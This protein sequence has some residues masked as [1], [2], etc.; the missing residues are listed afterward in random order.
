MSRPPQPPI[1]LRPQSCR[2]GPSRS[3]SG[4]STSWTNRRRT[5]PIG[6]SRSPASRSCTRC[7]CTCSKDS[8]WCPTPSAY[9]SS[10]S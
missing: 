1:H 4:T 3:R 7:G 2:V 9:T 5:F 10:T 6:G 8:T